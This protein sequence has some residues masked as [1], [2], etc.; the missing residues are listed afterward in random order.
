MMSVSS[1]QAAIEAARRIFA[2]IAHTF[3]RLGFVHCQYQITFPVPVSQPQII[4]ID[5]RD[6]MFANHFRGR[7]DADFPIV[8]K[9]TPL[10]P[11]E[12]YQRTET[13]PPNSNWENTITVVSYHRN[14][15]VGRMT[16]TSPPGVIEPR[17][18][19][20]RRL[21]VEWLVS[22]IHDRIATLLVANYVPESRVS[23]T[24][25]EREILRWTAEGKTAPEIG[26]ILSVS[27]HTVAF[28]VKNITAKLGSANKTQAAVKAAALGI[29][30]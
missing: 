20:A 2:E 1:N 15:A 28:H 5:S 8:E 21:L 9:P 26:Q 7:R 24:S 25:R 4:N 27:A 17:T 12:V 29:L 19:F 3:Q 30:R 22:S 10:L 6:D 11:D 18:L 13:A 23:L 16:I 14:G